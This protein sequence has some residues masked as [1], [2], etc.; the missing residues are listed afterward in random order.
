M[1]PKQSLCWKLITL[2]SDTKTAVC[3]LCK[4]ELQF[5]KRSNTN[6][7]RHLRLKH[8]FELAAFEE[9]SG[10]LSSL[11]STSST[12]TA[13]ASIGS[14][15]STSTATTTP[16]S[17]FSSTSTSTSATSTS[18]TR[19]LTIAA[20]VERT[21]KYKPDSVRKREL[22]ARVLDL[23]TVDMQPLSVV[24]NKAF[25][26][27]LNTLDPRYEIVSRKRLTS[28][29]L[30]QKY[31]EERARLVTMLE[32]ISHLSI[33]T[34]CW[35]S[36][37]VDSYMTVTVHLVTKDWKLHSRILSTMLL[38]GSHTADKLSSALRE[39]FASWGITGSQKVTHCVTDNVA[40]V[41][42]AIEQLRLRH[43]PCFAHTLNLVVKECIKEATIYSQPRTE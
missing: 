21:T 38:E 39:V 14:N 25:R 9:R 34:G 8:P 19:Q 12:E 35:T 37:A 30:P 42:A 24:E 31:Q 7:L 23:V 11:P 43:Q 10:Q 22:D 1:P 13:L 32:E 17:A 41:K 3:D 6:L 28:Q 18:S 36:R 40:N 4:L 16:T 27:L 15:T 33:T 5:N 26:R 29:M 2:K 20:T